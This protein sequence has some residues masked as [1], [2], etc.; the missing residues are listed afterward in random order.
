MAPL[1]LA[2]VRVSLRSLST[3]GLLTVWIRAASKGCVGHPSF[4]HR[5]GP[6][7]VASKV[8]SRDPRRE[9]SK[10]FWAGEGSRRYQLH[11]LRRRGHGSP[12]TQRRGQD[13]DAAHVA[14]ALMRPDQGSIMVD[15]VDAVAE[16][17][18]VQRHLGVLPD[19]SGLYAR[20]TAREHIECLVC[21]RTFRPNAD[22]THRVSDQDAR[23]EWLR[24]SADARLLAW[25]TNESRAGK[26]SC[27]IPGTSCSMNPPT[28]S[29]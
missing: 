21:Y 17:C 10:V 27:T 25:R 22:G 13:H 4:S 2:A 8:R 3:A 1:P 24:R 5:Q 6:I 11:G 14:C 28:V 23:H 20:L 9:P 15:G 26:G 12:R 19:V 18:K 29:M 7:L 16:P